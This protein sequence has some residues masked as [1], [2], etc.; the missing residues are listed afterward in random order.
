M[1]RVFILR[2]NLARECGHDIVRRVC[3]SCRALR[4][5][6]SGWTAWPPRLPEQPI[7]YPV[8]NKD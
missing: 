7:F 5:G 2:P 1:M 4:M 8:L 3:R 6:E